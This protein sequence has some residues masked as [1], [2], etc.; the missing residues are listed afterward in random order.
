MVNACKKG[1]RGEDELCEWLDKNLRLPEK[2][3]HGERT[4]RNTFQASGTDTDIIVEDFIIEVKRQETLKLKDFWWQ[5][6]IAAKNHPNKDL[7]PV[8]AFRQ[9]RKPWEFLLPAKLIGLEKGFIRLT[10]GTFIEF[11][12]KL[13]WDK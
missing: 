8:V 2:R 4:R 10:E 3:E 11:A 1:K 9:N 6:C 13:I 5:V 12:E 7:I